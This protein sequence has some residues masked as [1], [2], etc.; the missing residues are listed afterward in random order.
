MLFVFRFSFYFHS[1]SKPILTNP[2]KDTK[3]INNNTFS[4]PKRDRDGIWDFIFSFLS[5]WLA[6]R[7]ASPSALA[8]CVITWV[9]EEMGICQL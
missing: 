5:A 1:L 2:P 9:E 4:N 8:M 6:Q 3:K 7:V